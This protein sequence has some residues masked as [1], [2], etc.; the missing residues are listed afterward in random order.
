MLSLVNLFGNHIENSII[1]NGN[2][3]IYAVREASNLNPFTNIFR[4]SENSIS[5]D[6]LK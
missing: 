5:L 2:K 6:L 1:R 3:E 4:K